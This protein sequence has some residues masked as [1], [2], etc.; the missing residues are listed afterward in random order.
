MKTLYLE[1]NM[2]AAGDMLAAAL[3]ELLTQEEQILFEKKFQEL[4]L[5]GITLTAA[6]SMKCGI[7]GTHIEI[8]YHDQMESD[9]SHSHHEHKHEHEHQSYQ[10]ILHILNHLNLPDQV[11]NDAI[12]IY[13]SIAEAESQV[14]Q[15]TIE[16]VHFHEVGTM[17][18]ISDVLACCLLFHMISPDRILASPIHV[19]KGTVRCAHGILPVPA[20]ATALLLKQI[21]IYSG[22]INGEL[23]TPTGAAILAH[24]VQ[25]F[26]SM[27]P[28]RIQTIG[29]GM[30][31]K[32]FPVA[33]CV[34]GFLGEETQNFP[35]IIQIEC[36]VD[37]MTGE[38]LGFCMEE[39]FK[40]QALDFFYTPI[41]MKKNRPGI[42]ITCIC[43]LKDKDSIIEFLF[44][45]TTTRGVRFHE[46]SRVT[47][48]AETV[49]HQTSYGEV[50][51]KQ[52]RY[53]KYETTK[54]EYDDLS[55][56]AKENN[57]SIQDIR[58]ELFHTL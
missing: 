29:Y 40:F 4:E 8:H 12:A 16:Q 39:A 11:R 25:S 17:D 41:Q 46:L 33:N 22:E 26:E 37:D 51:V 47:M 58:K 54:P 45:H 44:Q 21:P 28:L 34:R 30:G 49:T 13:R 35:S 55:R 6:A 52:S 38:D 32:D 36:N 1:C 9:H 50:K 19:G 42:L 24:F 10:S 7:S 15:T 48:S 3:Y 2:G 23:C 14:H 5:P 43:N 31:T 20:P 53:G 56:L 18:A 57:C 27:P